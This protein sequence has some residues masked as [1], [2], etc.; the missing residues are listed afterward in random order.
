MPTVLF[1]GGGASAKLRASN[2]DWIAAISAIEEGMG[3]IGS[4][5][6][7]EVC[8]LGSGGTARALAFGSLERGAGQVTIANRTLSKAVGLAEELGCK[9]MSLDDLEGDQRMDGGV[10][11]NTTS[12]GMSGPNVDKAPVSETVIGRFDLIFDA[13]YNPLETKLLQT[14]ERLGK[15][16]VSGVEMFVGQAAEQ[17]KQFT[18]S[19]PPLE[20]MREKVM[21]RL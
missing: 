14:A 19:H 12:V 3:G 8:I 21:Q 9:A 11:I 1:M 16:T 18:G 7:K 15:P 17:F 4:L 10:L 20:L 2:T 5:A 6:G 13:I